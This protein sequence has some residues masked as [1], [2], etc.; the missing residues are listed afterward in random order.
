MAAE[1]KPGRFV[2][3]CVHARVLN[4]QTME[5]QLQQIVSG[6]NLL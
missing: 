1:S 4:K 5:Q 6:A 3:V 2:C